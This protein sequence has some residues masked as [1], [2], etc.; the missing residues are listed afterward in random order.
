MPIEAQD[1]PEGLKPEGI[2]KPEEH[3]LRAIE[4]DDKKNHL[5]RKAL[6]SLK[7]PGGCLP[8][9][10]GQMSNAGSHL[11]NPCLIL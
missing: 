3:F 7:E 10:E 2:G 11:L 6:H 4:I 1:T 9:V 8:I 5:F